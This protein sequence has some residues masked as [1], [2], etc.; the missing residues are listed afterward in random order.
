MCEVCQGYCKSRPGW[1]APGEA[2]EAAKLLGLSL[3]EFFNRR[4]VVDYWVRGM[5]ESDIYLLSPANDEN[6]PGEIDSTFMPGGQCVF[7][8]DGLC[9]IH[10]AKPLE[11]ALARHDRDKS[12]N[13]HQ[14]VAF[15]WNA[16]EHQAQIRDLLAY[17][18]DN[19]REQTMPLMQTAN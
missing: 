4:L 7:F 14:K 3:Q 18:E 1:F 11:C 2:E 13:I 15:M 5:D 19:S 17:T 8:Q 6:R 12:V 9:A 10:D 16:P